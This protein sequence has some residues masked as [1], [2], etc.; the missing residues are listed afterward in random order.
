MPVGGAERSSGV[1]HQLMV[2][3]VVGS[4]PFGGPIMLAIVSV[5]AL[6][7]VCCCQSKIVVHEMMEE[8]S[9]VTLCATSYNKN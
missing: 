4:I 5:Y 3:W 9:I 6:Q 2:R 8:W 7:L 1:Q